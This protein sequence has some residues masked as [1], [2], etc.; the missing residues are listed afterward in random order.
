MKPIPEK[1]LAQWREL[2]QN[3][4]PKSTPVVQAIV[5]ALLDEIDLERAL[6][7]RVRC[8]AVVDPMG[9]VGGINAARMFGI[10]RDI[11][12]LLEAREMR[13]PYL[14]SRTEPPVSD[15]DIRTVRD[16][17]ASS[18]TTTIS[19][20]NVRRLLHEIDLLRAEV[21]EYERHLHVAQARAEA[22][23]LDKPED[24]ETCRE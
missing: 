2:A 5:I 17:V 6:L 10:E 21:K 14:W 20:R 4:D 1:L 7:R 15:E 3:L 18:D 12:D 22:R 19:Q 23:E 11:D 16:A 13:E 8:Y 9:S 24:G